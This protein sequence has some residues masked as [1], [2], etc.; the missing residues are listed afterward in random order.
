M[1]VNKTKNMVT[2]A[3]LLTFA[4]LISKVLSAG[5]R[6]PLQNLTGDFGFFVYQQIYPLIGIIMILSLYGFPVAVSTLVVGMKQ[7]GYQLIYKTF[8]MPLLIVLYVINGT[9]FL[10]IFL[11]ASP[12][13][14]WIGMAEL[15]R[16]FQ[17]VSF[18]FLLIPILT[19]LRGAFQG[20][21]EMKQTAISQVG[22]QIVRVVIIIIAAILIFN[23]Q[24]DVY[25]LG[26]IGAG[27]TI[28]GMLAAI[29]ILIWFMLK[30]KG[31]K[32][33]AVLSR[34]PWRQY[35]TSVISL[36]V[37]AA[38][39][40]MILLITQLADVLTLVPD[41]MKSGL[42]TME[43]MEMKGVFDRGQPLIQFGAVIGSSF[44]LALIPTI[45]RRD[46]QSV[47][48]PIGNALA[49]SFYVAAGATIG[50]IILFPEVNV[51]LFQSA[52]G[53]SSLQ[54]LVLAI[55]LSSLAI[56]ACTI[57]Q[58]LGYMKLTA[59]F[60]ISTFMMKYI[61]NHLLVPSAGITGASIATVGSLLLLCILLLITLKWKVS[62]FS[63]LKYIKVR[64]LFIAGIGMMIYLLVIKFSTAFIFIP[65]RF[66]LLLYV[67][68]LVLTGAFVYL[69]LLLRYN[70][71]SD[72]QL[73]ALPFSRYI[74]GFSQLVS[75]KE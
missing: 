6:I 2:G 44:S 11:L 37:I 21:E 63:I 69:S 43:A 29:A 70:A 28:I 48:D 22:E 57:L 52:D 20:Q 4:G 36:G 33:G 5:Y 8:Y 53:T 31:N 54:I 64:A 15:A 47:S 14:N 41:L 32:T 12:L 73:A 3:L 17:L 68:F 40:H 24:L 13:A 30:R 39:I 42:T 10:T 38:F 19:L 34:V 16:A 56:T 71:F 49:L 67:L 7:K 58:N 62:E 50:L 25:K 1:D 9:V 60:I 61:L 18:A 55:I 72:K 66:G 27:A 59:L 75:K 26:E 35:F 51:L 23:E 46:Q 74:I 45:N 65:S